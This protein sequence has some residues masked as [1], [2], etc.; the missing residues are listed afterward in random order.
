MAFAFTSRK[1][2]KLRLPS[3]LW[4]H[5]PCLMKQDTFIIR[6]CRNWHLGHTMATKVYHTSNEAGKRLGRKIQ[7]GRGEKR[8]HTL[9]FP[10]TSA[11]ARNVLFLTSTFIYPILNVNSHNH[12]VRSRISTNMLFSA[13]TLLREHTIEKIRT[14]VIHTTYLGEEVDCQSYMIS[15]CK[16]S[17]AMQKGM[18]M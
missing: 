3:L 18:A 2:W 17:F 12:A 13:N 9:S 11:N 4:L 5:T 15:G 6:Q 8:L 10:Y 14:Y 7:P 1:P 16:S